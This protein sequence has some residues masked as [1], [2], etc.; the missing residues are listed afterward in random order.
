MHFSTLVPSNRARVGPQAI[1]SVPT[2]GTG[3]TVLG[4]SCLVIRALYRYYNF[5]D[6]EK[7]AGN[8]KRDSCNSLGEVVLDLN[9]M[10]LQSNWHV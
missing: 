9:V 5:R 10:K 4:R 1:S 8:L 2:V 3:V 6:E 7:M